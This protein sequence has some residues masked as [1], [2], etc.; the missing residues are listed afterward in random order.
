[1]LTA[2]WRRA[3]R[4]DEPRWASTLRTTPCSSR[5]RARRFR[6]RPRPPWPRRVRSR[7]PARDL[8]ETCAPTLPR[9][10]RPRSSPH[11]ALDR[12][13]WHLES[14]RLARFA[15]ARESIDRH[16]VVGGGGHFV[17]GSCPS[18]RRSRD[19][20]KIVKRSKRDAS[21]RD[22]RAEAWPTHK[23]SEAEAEAEAG[24]SKPTARWSIRH[25]PAQSDR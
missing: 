12:G 19:D 14:S 25:L 20:A 13:A 1:M 17:C 7:R 23:K 8:R 18:S 2:T 16:R 6:E 4:R 9:C 10:S 5:P 22:V 15:E 11:G 21:A 24:L 3:S